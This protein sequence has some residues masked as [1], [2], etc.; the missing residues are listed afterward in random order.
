MKK[1]KTLDVRTRQ[2]WHTWLGKHHEAETEIWLVFHKRHTGR[3]SVDYHDSVDEALCF[4]WIDSLIRRLDDERYAR[5]FT[6]RKPDSKWSTGNRRRYAALKA[7]GLLAPAGQKRAPTAGSSYPAR[8]TA[9][10]ALPRYIERA[11]RSNRSAWKY[12]EQLAPS[13]RRMYVGWIDSAKRP[14]TKEKRLREAIGL[15]AEGRKI[16]LK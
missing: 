11:L 12:F 7:E 6:P 5:K 13:H 14:E 15:L 8:P 16:G 4:G 9:T 10:T 2:A 1:L 3:T